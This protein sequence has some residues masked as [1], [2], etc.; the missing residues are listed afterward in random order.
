M[1]RSHHAAREVIGEHEHRHA[2]FSF[3]VHGSYVE[4]VRGVA[5]S[6]EPYRVRFHPAGEVHQDT[7]GSRRTH[8]LNFQLDD[9]WTTD[10][11]S[12]GLANANDVLIVPDAAWS[13]LGAWRHFT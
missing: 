12:L 8:V 5:V 3:V 9:T 1:D 10:V 13:C 6:C 2:Y 7:F 11:E 4:T